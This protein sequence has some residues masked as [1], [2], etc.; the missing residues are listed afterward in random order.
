[1]DREHPDSGHPFTLGPTMTLRDW[2][3]AT[4]SEHDIDEW[5]WGGRTRTQARYRHADEMLKVRGGA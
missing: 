1:M 3:A 5:L 4:A 2:F